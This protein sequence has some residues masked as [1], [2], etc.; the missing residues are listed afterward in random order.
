MD[1]KRVYASPA[2]AQAGNWV[3]AATGMANQ[4]FVSIRV[5]KR[6]ARTI[7]GSNFRK[8]TMRRDGTFA[9]LCEP[10]PF[11][12]EQIHAPQAE[13]TWANLKLNPPAK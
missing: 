10:T 11:F 4:P 6:T 5:T 8:Y 9:R 1:E 2:S 7:T 13:V 12:L 3:I